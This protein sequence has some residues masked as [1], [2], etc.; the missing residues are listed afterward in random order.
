MP[1]RTSEAF[2]LKTYKLAEVDKI[3]VFLT[4]SFGKVRGVARGARKLK[5][6]YGAS[7]E[8]FTKV[9]LT[10][11]EKE[12]RELVSIK[13]CDILASY[14]GQASDVE[15]VTQLSYLFELLDEFLPE[16]EPNEKLY[17][18]VEAVLDAI[19]GAG[20]GEPVVREE[21][22]ALARYFEVWLLRLS[23]F[24]PDLKSCAICGSA[25]SPQ[26][27]LWLAGDGTP[28]CEKCSGGR[29]ERVAPNVRSVFLKMFGSHPVAFSKA[30]GDAAELARI[31]EIN[32]QLIRRCIERDVRSYGVLKQ[33]DSKT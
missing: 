19:G 15:I 1:L 6:I 32:H 11:F 2:V 7:L 27:S 8:P 18:L 13:T 5:S 33:L 20:R 25:F 4:R 9:S 14:F 26:Q 23:G 31:K 12:G 10:F 22:E 21:V 3:C 24:F 28:Q 16:H 17:R 30:A 29:G